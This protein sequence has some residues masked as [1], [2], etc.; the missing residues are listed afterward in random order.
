MANYKNPIEFENSLIEIADSV[1]KNRGETQSHQK[2]GEGANLWELDYVFIPKKAEGMSSHTYV[3]EFK[4]SSS[5]TLADSILFTQLARFSALEKANSRNALRF[6]LVTNGKVSNFTL[7]ITVTVLD[8][9]RD[10]TDWR[11]KITDW[12]GKEVPAWTQW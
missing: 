4:Y 8:E 5:P 6:V 9:I 3:F 11:K 7:P 1:L 2:I 12:L 10:S